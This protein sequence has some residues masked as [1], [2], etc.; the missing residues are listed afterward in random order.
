MSRVR[1]KTYWRAQNAYG[2]FKP[3]G[4][5]TRSEPPEVACDAAIFH[6]MKGIK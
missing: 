5:A 1:D 2:D 6:I 4:L 3:V